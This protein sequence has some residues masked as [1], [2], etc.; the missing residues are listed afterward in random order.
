MPGRR[1]GPS[2]SS[3]Q[4]NRTAAGR[5]PAKELPAEDRRRRGDIERFDRAI[6]GNP[7]QLF[8]SARNLRRK[9]VLLVD[10]VLLE[11]DPGKKSA[12]LARFPS[13]EQ[14][15]FTFLPDEGWRSYRTPDTLVLEVE[16]G[17]FLEPGELLR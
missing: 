14:A 9:P 16:A 17:D 5:T 13:Y 10:D 7:H 11:L 12:F 8:A 15:F 6:P 3:W 4:T 2:S 1:F